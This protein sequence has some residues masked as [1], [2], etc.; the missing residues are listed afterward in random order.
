MANFVL[1]SYAMLAYFR[2]EPGGEK[3][4]QLLN[5]TAEGKHH[6]FMTCINAG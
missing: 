6:L 1:D 5:E 4:E 3:I 2:N